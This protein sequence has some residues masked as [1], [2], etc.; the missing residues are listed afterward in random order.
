MYN[1]TTSTL[2]KVMKFISSNRFR[3]LIIING[4]E[5][6]DFIQN[7]HYLWIKSSSQ[8]RSPVLWCYKSRKNHR[9]KSK[10]LVNN[11]IK[12]DKKKKLF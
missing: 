6:N 3:S 9:K 5:I 1:E 12:A 11:E 2:L 4:K 7:I 8:K 10:F